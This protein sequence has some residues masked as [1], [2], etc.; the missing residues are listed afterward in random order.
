MNFLTKIRRNELRQAVEDELKRREPGRHEELLA[1]A[2][3]YSLR[4]RLQALAASGEI[5][6]SKRKA[7]ER[8]AQLAE[9]SRRLAAMFHNKSRRV[10]QPTSNFTLCDEEDAHD[11]GNA[12][13]ECNVGEGDS[14]SKD[15]AAAAAPTEIAAKE[16]TESM[17]FT[18][19]FDLGGDESDD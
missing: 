12:A 7:A 19:E 8:A 15:C 5:D 9:Q 11:Y 16:H 4:A 13:N 1:E 2:Q 18:F 6:E 10:Q 3:K 17:P 14:R